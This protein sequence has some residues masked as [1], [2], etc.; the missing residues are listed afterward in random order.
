MYPNIY[1]AKGALV[2][3]QLARKIEIGCDG[4]EYQ[5]IPADFSRDYRVLLNRAD[6]QRLIEKFPAAVVHPPLGYSNMEDILTGLEN[7]VME[8]SMRMAQ[9][10]AAITGQRTMVVVHVNKSRKTT[11]RQELDTIA[12]EMERLFKQFPDVDIVLE[13]LSILNNISGGM[14]DMCNGYYDANVRFAEYFEALFGDNGE[15]GRRVM[16]CLDVCHVCLDVLYMSAIAGVIE[17]RGGELKLADYSL[18]GYMEMNAP[19]IGLVHLAAFENDGYGKGHGTPFSLDGG[20]RSL[21][22]LENFMRA[23]DELDMSCPVTLEVRENDY[24]VADGYESSLDA[25]RWMAEHLG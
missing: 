14:T 12:F 3:E 1:Y 22:V 11:T 17:S 23:Y 6:K 24:L 5:L 19:F 8:E 10:S 9:I 25:A 13:N 4:I 16:T 7:V 2:E 15:G 18:R 20:G 21:D